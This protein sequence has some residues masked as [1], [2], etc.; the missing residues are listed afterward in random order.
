MDRGLVKVKLFEAFSRAQ[1]MGGDEARVA[2]VS[3]YPQ[4]DDLL[5]EINE[6]WMASRNKIKVLA[7]K[8]SQIFVINSKMV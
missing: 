8:I 4:P 7:P 5:E 3:G 2:L 6:S 1:Q